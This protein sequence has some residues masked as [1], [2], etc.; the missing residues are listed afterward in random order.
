[1]NHD[2]PRVIRE[3]R[4]GQ[5]MLRPYWE[6]PE[7]IMKNMGMESYLPTYRNYKN[8]DFQIDKDRMILENPWIKN[9][10]QASTLARAQ[11]RE[12]VQSVDAFLYRWVYPGNPRH[13]LNLAMPEYE[14]RDNEVEIVW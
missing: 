8:L 6:A 11:M 10:E 5:K 7:M 9:V 14:L 12:Q 2:Q 4:Q 1:M 3:L 13:P